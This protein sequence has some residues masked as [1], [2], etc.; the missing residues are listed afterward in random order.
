MNEPPFIRFDGLTKRFGRE[1]AVDGLSLDIRRGEFFAL[2][3][4][5]G[6]GKTTL[7]RLLAG[8]ET[9]DEGRVLLDG[10][11]MAGLEAHLRP[12]NMMFQSYALF[13]HMNVAANIGFGLSM[14]GMSAKAVSARVDELLALVRLEGFGARKPS[15]LSGGQKQR[16]ALAR[17]L[18]RQ[19]KALLLDEPLGALD[20]ALREEMQ[21]ELKSLQQKLGVTFLV[22]THDQD[23]AL[24]L[25][26]RMAVMDRGRIVQLGTPQEIYERPASLAVA[27]FIGS[28]N[29]VPAHAGGG[30]I[31]TP[32]GTVAAA[33]EGDGFLVFRP[34]KLKEGQAGPDDLSIEGVV[35]NLAYRGDTTAVTFH[36]AGQSLHALV[37]GAGVLRVGETVQL[38]LPA[39]SG[40]FLNE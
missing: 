34:E 4:P 26:D 19:P 17:A 31:A 12:L 30:S 6:C 40:L 28:I 13:P 10:Q 24:S 37:P 29:A 27:R 38:V 39:G 7:M 23:E 1:A 2:L 20:K 3:G 11:D 22:V 14:A 9:P 18:A 5:S 36:A 25:A 33:G 16:V 35:S 21:G 32:F 15:S 8:F